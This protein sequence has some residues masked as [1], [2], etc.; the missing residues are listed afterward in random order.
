[1]LLSVYVCPMSLQLNTAL[2]NL[3]VSQS[4]L[5]FPTTDVGDE[6]FLLV[7]IGQDGNEG[8]VR[9][10]SESAFFQV[11]VQA[12]PLRFGAEVTFTPAPGGTF[13]HVRYAPKQGGRHIG[14]LTIEAGEATQT[15]LLSGRTTGFLSRLSPPQ[16]RAYAPPQLALPAPRPTAAVAAERV[17]NRYVTAVVITIGVVSLSA[18]AYWGGTR[19]NVVPQPIPASVAP[20]ATPTP[21]GTDDG[22]PTR[23]VAKTLP[24]AKTRPI[25]PT[26]VPEREQPRQTDVPQQPA[27]PTGELPAVVAPRPEPIRAE[28]MRPEPVRAEPVRPAAPRPEPVRVA[29]VQAE[30]TAPSKAR[31]AARPSAKRAVTEPAKKRLPKPAEPTSD[32]SEL[33][34]A[35]NKN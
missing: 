5:N 34:R 19:R 20:P 23:M 7:K 30:T 11:A 17:T 28:P 3:F 8:P 2:S 4:A 31:P 1:M 14:D 24:T 25:Q 26:V 27:E 10:V 22:K 13:I 33:E 16:R 6:R 15:V 29:T 9:V 12:S 35:L 32:E 21:P 18:L